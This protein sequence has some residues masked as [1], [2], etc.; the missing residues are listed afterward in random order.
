M[1]TDKDAPNRR[2]IA[3]DLAHPDPASW[4]VVVPEQPQA[5]ENVARRSA[6]A[7]SRN[8]W[9]T[10]RAGCT[11]SASTAADSEIALPAVGTV[12]GIAGRDEPYD[13]WYLFSSPLTPGTVYRYDPEPAPHRIRGAGAADRHQRV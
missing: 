11:C 1:R 10:C 8:I 3:I 2:V 13:V 6:A 9:S 5:I 12:S 7:S 4:K